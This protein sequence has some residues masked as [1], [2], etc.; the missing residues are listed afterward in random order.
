[1]NSPRLARGHYNPGMAAFT[2]GLPARFP[3]DGS[4][5]LSAPVLFFVMFEA[6][7]PGTQAVERQ[8]EQSAEISDQNGF[9]HGFQEL[10]RAIALG[11][12]A[13]GRTYS[14]ED[15]HTMMDAHH[16][17]RKKWILFSSPRKND[18]TGGMFFVDYRYTFS[19]RLSCSSRRYGLLY[20]YS[21]L[22]QAFAQLILAWLKSISGCCV[23]HTGKES[24]LSQKLLIS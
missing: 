3:E 6:L 13:H 18:P 14:Q 4:A 11:V 1:M 2:P 7:C 23:E 8:M 15:I 24:K 22:S 10:A 17:P 5:L 16:V 9:K 12:M 19:E 21:V 20:L